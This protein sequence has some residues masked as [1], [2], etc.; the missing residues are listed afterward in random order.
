MAIIGILGFGYA[1]YLEAT[2]PIT[3]TEG[4]YPG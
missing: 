2:A 4:L 3:P 1:G